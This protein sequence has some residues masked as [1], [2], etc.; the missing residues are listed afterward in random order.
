[1]P[2]RIDIELTSA[3]DD[4]SWT[5][6]AAG[7]REPRGVLDGSLLPGGVS[8]GDQLKV[9]AEYGVDGISI[10]SI[11]PPKDKPGR[12]L[13]ELLPAETE[14]EPVTQQRAKR[15]DDRSDRRRSRR[16]DRRPGDRRDGRHGDDRPRGERRERSEGESRGGERREPRGRRRE[17]TPPPEVPK[18]P[19]PKRLR[20]GRTRRNE[21]LGDLPEAQ[22][23]IA[24]LVLQGMPAVR[25]R[26]RDDNAV[27]KAEGKPEMPEDSVLSMAESLLPRLRVADWL[28]R[29]EAARRQME[30]LDLRDLRSVVASSDDPIVARDESTRDLATEMKA[31]L[32]SKQEEELALWLTDVAAALD[33]GR[34]IRALRLSSQPPKAGVPFP[35]ELAGRLADATNASLLPDDGA[36]R[37][38]AVLEAAAFSPIR[39]QVQPKDVPSPVSDELKSTVT[40]LAPLLPQIAGQFGIEVP[41]GVPTPKPLRPTRPTKRPPKGPKDTQVG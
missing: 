11:V 23:S 27:L 10:L 24:E 31:A 28:D 34:V 3:R 18:R 17:F 2:N 19:K 15:S 13:L 30:H 14:F 32:A 37:W 22:R 4:G 7:A 5:W 1:M 20:P 35:T 29:A 40:R 26:L 36:D 16:D 39:A 9:E 41:T 8:V 25:Q 6:R 33:V 12:E 21:V 38:A